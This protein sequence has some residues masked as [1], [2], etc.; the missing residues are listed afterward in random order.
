[1]EQKTREKTLQR[2]HSTPVVARGGGGEGLG[3]RSEVA[4]ALAAPLPGVREQQKSKSNPSPSAPAAPAAPP[5][6]AP[7]S[8]VA[9]R[10]TS[11]PQPFPEAEPV[12]ATVLPV[13]RPAGA[14]RG[15]SGDSRVPTGTDDAA[16][17]NRSGESARP[18][19]ESQEGR[20]D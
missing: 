3:E 11:A 12:F 13:A 14:T 7:Q 8:W 4:A 10:A 16:S 20:T 6:T 2:A 5:V 18:P 1:M 19:F 17:S 9:S 15:D